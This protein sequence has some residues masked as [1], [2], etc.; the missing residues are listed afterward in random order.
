MAG[1]TAKTARTIGVIST[2]LDDYIFTGITRG[3]EAALTAKGHRLQL[4]FT[5]NM[6]ENE[7]RVLCSM[8]EQGVD[9]LIVEP[10]KSGLPLVNSALYH[11][12]HAQGIPL[13]FFNSYYPSLP[14]FPH[15]SMNDVEAGRRSATCLLERG[16]RKI[17]GIFQCDDLQ[18]HRRY[19]GYIRALQE[20]RVKLDSSR[21]LWFATGDIPHLAEDFARVERT[22]R[23]CTGLICYNDQVAFTLC[24]EFARRG[25]RVPEDL[26]LSSIDN[27]E[28]AA[29]CTPPLTSV[30]H[31]METLGSTAAEHILRLIDE[32]DFDATVEFPP[33]VVERASIRTV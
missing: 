29:I 7:Q 28:L 19:E 8:L 3:I 20:Y 27:S 21:I 1:A 5:R 33:P 25:V 14:F 30:G 15:V 23:G 9:G 31:P 4:A 24:R 2:Y 32:P 18:G 26:S 6:V 10:T 13:M 17:A 16:H 11:R 22:I 12:I